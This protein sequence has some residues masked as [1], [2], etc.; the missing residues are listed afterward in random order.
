[1]V[2]ENDFKLLGW[3]FHEIKAIGVGN[4]QSAPE[5]FKFGHIIALDLRFPKCPK[6]LKSERRFKSY[7]RYREGG[8]SVGIDLSY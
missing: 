1:M 4:S 3:N 6:F 2:W 7:D 5:H 8:M